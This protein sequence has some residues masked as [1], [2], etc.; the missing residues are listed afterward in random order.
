MFADDTNFFIQGENDLNIVL[1]KLTIWLKTNKLSLNIQ[2]TH[3]MT[4]S[5]THSI[6]TRH[7]KIYIDG[8]EIDIVNYTNFQGIVILQQTKLE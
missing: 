2:K 4:F 1:K 7:N 6:R 8:T 3:T 5:N